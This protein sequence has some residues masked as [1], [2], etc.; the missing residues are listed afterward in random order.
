MLVY[1][2]R[3][4]TIIVA[5]ALLQDT[6]ARQA[7]RTLEHHLLQ[8]ALGVSVEGLLAQIQDLRQDQASNEVPCHLGS[9]VNMDR[10]DDGL[11]HVSA[12]RVSRPLIKGAQVGNIDPNIGEKAKR[13]PDPGQDTP[14]DY[15]GFESGH[16]AF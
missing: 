3:E 15:L 16:L 14:T 8:P 5:P 1:T 13:L 12:E 6:V 9:L 2:H 4:N 11:Q 10:A 7:A